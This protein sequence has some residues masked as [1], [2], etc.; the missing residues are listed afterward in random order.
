M[1]T[2]KFHIRVFGAFAFGARD[3]KAFVLGTKQQAL[4][5]LLATA[6]GGT[7]TRSWLQCQLWGNVQAAQASGSLRNAL[8]TIRRVVGPD[9]DAL[10][11]ATRERVTID[12]DALM[13]LGTPADGEFLE[14]LDV[15][16][17]EE[18]N[19]W[20][21]QQRAYYEA[22]GAESVAPPVPAEPPP[23]REVDEAPPGDVAERLDLFPYVAV[24]PF[25]NRVEASESCVF[26][27]ALA[28]DITRALSRSGIFSV[29]SHL[30]SRYF[31]AKAA[32]L[33]EVTAALG[34]RYLLTGETITRGDRFRLNVDLHDACSGRMVW[35]QE[36]VG[37]I[38]DFLRG[39]LDLARDVVLMVARSAMAEAERLVQSMPLPSLSCHEMLMGAIALMH[40]G[41]PSGFEHAWRLLDATVD[42]VPAHSVPRAWLGKWHVLKVQKGLSGDIPADTQAALDHTAR[43]LDIDPHCSVSLSFDG[44]VHSHLCRRIDVA[45]TRYRQAV[46]ANANDAF[47]WLLYGTL[48]AFRNQPD[49]AVRFTTRA[50]R[51]SPL[52]PQRYYFE[53]LSATAHLC[54][55]HYVEALEL[56]ETS[57]RRNRRHPS[58]LRV[59]TIALQ[60]LGRSAEARASAVELLRVEPDLTVSGYL[61]RHPAATYDTGR[62][63]AT[64]LGEAGVPA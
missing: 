3:G 61:A 17:E 10:I 40:G 56:A 19:D 24:L 16:Y 41:K 60:R 55:G 64:A 26:G 51:L 50:R 2:A 49:E 5:A 37:A 21:R 35:S 30:S 36:F 58:T 15:K 48:H 46:D 39:E 57:L 63:W 23:R 6:P 47:A 62:D 11:S 1:R 44:F 29:T 22:H 14:G 4:L 9:C 45:E 42:R 31:A 28:E 27:D 25:R 33:P 7:R 52:D 43:A 38:S 8:S 54:A 18:F 53:S 32:T 12:L 34:V 59:K 20:L 13:V